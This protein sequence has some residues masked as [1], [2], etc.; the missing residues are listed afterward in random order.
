MRGGGPSRA[1]GA[2]AP[3]AWMRFVR[4]LERFNEVTGYLSGIVIVAWWVTICLV[5]HAVRLVQAGLARRHG[6]LRSWLN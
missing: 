4:A 3:A 1:A 5:V 2:Q 6:P